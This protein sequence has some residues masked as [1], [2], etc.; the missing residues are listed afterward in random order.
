MV[1]DR[2]D[3]CY[4]YM[5]E[6][7]RAPIRSKIARK[8]LSII[9]TEYKTLPFASRWLSKEMKPGLARMALRELSRVG[10]I[11]KYHPLADIKGSVVSQSEHTVIVKKSGV[12]IL[13]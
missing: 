8:A 7:R 4:I 13:T 6:Q 2:V 1:H 12:E 5:L 9:N 11:R 10:L 3:Q